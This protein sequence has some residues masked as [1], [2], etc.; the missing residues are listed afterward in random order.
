MKLVR[1][2]KLLAV[3]LVAALSGSVLVG[4]GGESGSSSEGGVTEQ[5]LVFNLGED[6]KT[7]DPA[8]NTSSGASTVI[9]NAFEGL[10]SLD[11]EDK[12]KPGVA[13]K[14][15]I[16]DDKLTYTFH[17]RDNAK[18]SDGQ[19]VTAKDFEYAWK[20]ALDPKTGAEYAYQLYYIEGAEEYNKG[21]GDADKVAI[22]ALDDKTLEVKLVNPTPYFLELTAFTTYLPVREDIV[23][24]ND[25]WATDAK[26]YVSNG[27]FKLVEWRMKDA[28]VFE[29]N[30]NYWD[31]DEVNLEELEMRMI[32]EDTS[33]F[34]S[35]QSEEI[36]MLN[37]L[38]TAEIQNAVNNGI[39]KIFPQI[40]TYFYIVNVSG[41][42]QGNDALKNPKVTQAL[43]MAINR[44]AIVENVTKGGQTPA[45]SFVPTSIEDENGKQFTKEY[46]KSEGDIEGAKKLLEEAG[47]PNGEGLPTLTLMYN[48]EGAHGDVAQAVQA[49]WK[50]IG[51][52]VE[53]Q[54]Q[55]WKVFLDTRNNLNYQIARHGWVGD[56]VDPMT[57]LD[58][59]TTGNGNN[60]S[61]YSSAEYDKSIE[62]AKKEV[63]TNKRKELLNK[64]E[65]ILMSDMPIIPLYYYT[66]PKGIQ[67]YVKGVEVSQLGKISFKNAS[68]EK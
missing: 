55:E 39:A 44:E 12:A 10:C 66:Q 40:G 58:M 21:K 24:G 42:G 60:D 7:I 8:L 49:M 3:T 59:W 45:A 20:R 62:D 57:F 65:D 50:E 52:N 23:A 18:W 34:A 27:P 47:Y 29:K 41:K 25:G 22:K 43:N 11:S 4:C 1:L 64:A 46:F 13:E 48:T 63:D 17:L 6:P 38:P 37:S 51:V 14:W 68:I 5:K 35:F 36:D 2:K 67:P 26:T 31:T 53:L 19:P 61:G 9:G 16:S 32:S 30:E 54:N 15:E 56:Y 33:A 28:F